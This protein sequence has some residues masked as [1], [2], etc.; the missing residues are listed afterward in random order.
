[1]NDEI[2]RLKQFCQVNHECKCLDGTFEE[3]N[4]CCGKLNGIQ[5]PIG[6][7][8][9][10]VEQMAKKSQTKRIRD[11]EPEQAQKTL[12]KLFKVLDEQT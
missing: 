12:E 5:N 9:N 11:M 1:M 10:M 2:E 4:E 3:F 7:L 6:I 8:F